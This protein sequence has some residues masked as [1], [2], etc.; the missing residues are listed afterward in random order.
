MIEAITVLNANFSHNISDQSRSKA[1]MVKK[2]KKKLFYRSKSSFCG[3]LFINSF[4]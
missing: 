1:N 2:K 4:T 3:V